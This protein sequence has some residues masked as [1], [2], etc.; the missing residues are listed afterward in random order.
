[1]L[2]LVVP[3]LLEPSL[4]PFELAFADVQHAAGAAG[5]AAGNDLD[6]TGG[7]TNVHHPQ[8]FSAC[9]RRPGVLTLKS[10]TFPLNKIVDC[11]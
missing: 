1:M 11:V 3:P 6:L 9:Y 2:E 8:N 5:K 4:Q 10:K 7:G